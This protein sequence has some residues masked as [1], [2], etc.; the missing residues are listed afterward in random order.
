MKKQI[1]L[2]CCQLGQTILKHFVL[3]VVLVC[4]AACA[5]AM[6]QVVISGTN[7]FITPAA[8]VTYSLL[9]G[10]TSYGLVSRDII[11]SGSGMFSSFEN[12]QAPNN[13]RNFEQGVN[14]ISSSSGSPAWDTS[15]TASKS[16]EIKYGSF[17]LNYSTIEG[18]QYYGFAL[19]ANET[20]GGN[21]ND[22]LSL[23][24]MRLYATA[25]P[26]TGF[27]ATT[28]ADPSLL[29]M[30]PYFSYSSSDSSAHLL[31]TMD[32]PNANQEVLL[33]AAWG[34]AGSGKSDLL[35]WVPKEAFT[36]VKDTDNVYLWTQLGNADAYAGAPAPPGAQ[37]NDKSPYYAV[38]TGPEEWAYP[39][40]TAPAVPEPAEYG[41][42]FVLVIGLVAGL[43]A[44]KKW[45]RTPD[46]PV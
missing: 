9:T 19:D 6:A 42:A 26:K 29:S 4:L 11:G 23:D 25:A 36:G 46:K 8:G 44:R 32:K 10:Q 40:S 30:A 13:K 24:E 1:K 22:W 17:K 12:L 14:T 45:L 18:R 27:P 37:S 16:Y 33:N 38:G 3:G 21:L 20:G 41:L 15:Y 31:W 2:P 7:T 43:E 5:T 35:V 34:A 39:L 28:T